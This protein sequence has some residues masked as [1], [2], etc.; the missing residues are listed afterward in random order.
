MYR[1]LFRPEPQP[2]GASQMRVRVRYVQ[3]SSTHKKAPVPNGL[4]LSRFYYMVPRHR[5]NWRLRGPVCLGL[6][7]CFPLGIHVGIHAAQC[8][9][10]FLGNL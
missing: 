5:L 7:G 2:D 8:Y 6:V 4:R 1:N 3:F 10:G 9:T